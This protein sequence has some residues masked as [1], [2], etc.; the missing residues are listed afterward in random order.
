MPGRREAGQDKN[1]Q[2]SVNRVINVPESHTYHVYHVRDTVWNQNLPE[3]V[4]IDT[5]K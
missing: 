3:R 2:Q 5:V 4:P 1:R